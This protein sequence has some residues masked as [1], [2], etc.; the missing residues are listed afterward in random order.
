MKH[1]ETHPTQKRCS[2]CKQVLRLE[3]FRKRKASK[4]GL[5]CYCKSCHSENV[6][7][8]RLKNP[9]RVKQNRERYKLTAINRKR[10]QDYGISPEQYKQMLHNQNGMCAI[11]GMTNEKLV[12]DH[13]HETGHVR[14]LLCHKCNSGIGM[15]GDDIEILK[16][17]IWYLELTKHEA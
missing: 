13:C 1:A 14:G 4:D 5:N 17:A 16:C 8:W 7:Q 3:F 2:G 11:C 10:S 9:E 15:L 6:R 12:I